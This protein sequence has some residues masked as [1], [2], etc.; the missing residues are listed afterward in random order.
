MSYSL[1][2]ARCSRL[3][4]GVVEAFVSNACF[5]GEIVGRFCETPSRGS[6]SDTDALQHPLIVG[7]RWRPTFAELKLV[8]HILQTRR[9]SFNLLLLP[10]NGC[11]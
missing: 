7:N 1:A 9:K 4:L 2:I 5:V 3:N 11:F 10:G 6:A 8:A